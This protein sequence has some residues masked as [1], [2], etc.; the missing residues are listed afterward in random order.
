[1]SGT[2]LA[3]RMG[4]SQQA[5]ADLESSEQRDTIRIE[6]LRRVA[7]A[8]DCNLVYALVPRTSLDEAV[9]RQAKRRAARLVGEAAHHNR[10]EDQ[11]I[12][13]EDTDQMI[14][15]LADRFLDRRGLW[16]E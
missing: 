11:A 15:D 8:L 4:V 3:V 6:T 13:P 5:V 16:S 9:R 12:S 14:N 2:D 7:D 10:L 1:M